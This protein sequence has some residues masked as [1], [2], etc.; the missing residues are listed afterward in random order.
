MTAPV[1]T[2][3]PSILERVLQR[4]SE[5]SCSICLEP[6]GDGELFGHTTPE[7]VSHIFHRDC[8][9]RL[10]HCARIFGNPLRCPNCRR[11][12]HLD[13]APAEENNQSMLYTAVDRIAG[14][15]PQA[16]GVAAAVV[17]LNLGIVISILKRV[18][19]R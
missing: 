13:E 3:D 9:T 16:I 18:F 5:G 19:H 6:Y 14:I 17:V 1:P 11:V 8:T 15:V 4:P 10:I 2:V 12:I 7:H